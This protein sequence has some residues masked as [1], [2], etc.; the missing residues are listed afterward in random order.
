MGTDDDMAE[1][2][3]DLAA[4]LSSVLPAL[5]IEVMVFDKRGQERYSCIEDVDH[6]QA[7]RRYAFEHPTTSSASGRAVLS[8]GGEQ[9]LLRVRRIDVEGETMN[10]FA[11][12][13]HETFAERLGIDYKDIFEV[14]R[15]YTASVM[16]IVERDARLSPRLSEAYRR[17]ATL[18]LEGEAGTGKTQLAELLYMQGDYT[19]QP[20]VHVS[21]DALSDRSWR[22]LLG[23]SDSPL[24]QNDLTLY[25]SG[26]HILTPT[27]VRQFISAMHDGA[28]CRRNRVVLSGDDIPGA[29]ESDA[30]GRIGDALHCAVCVATPIHDMQGNA[31]RVEAYLSYVA[32]VLKVDAPILDDEAKAALERFAWPRNY[33]QL[34]EVAE[35]LFI[36]AGGEAVTEEIVDTVLAQEGVIRHAVAGPSNLEGD[37]YVLRPLAETDRAIARLVLDHLGGN[38]TKTA[39]VLG[40][41]RTTL[42][43]L[44]KEDA[45]A[46]GVE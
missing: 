5:D 44:L 34:R 37:L 12:T 26:L 7:V 19:N 17:G 33:V 42:W 35:R 31:E 8:C 32:G 2:R 6:A 46:R 24:F 15:D 45:T 1:G 16:G 20:F 3:A 9:L 28:V 40:I 36:V 13:P 41:S 18:M 43:R 39:E 38:K 23:G 4:V 14:R 25:V 27:K 21:C 22:Y 11:I 30:V 29:G 10:V